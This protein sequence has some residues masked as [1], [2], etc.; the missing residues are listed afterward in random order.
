V[1][2]SQN[3]CQSRQIPHWWPGRSPCGWPSG[4][5]RGVISDVPAPCSSCWPRRGGTS[6]SAPAWPLVSVAAHRRSS[7]PLSPAVVSPARLDWYYGRLRRPPSRG[8]TS[9]GHRLWDAT[10]PTTRPPRCGLG[11]ATSSCLLEPQGHEDVRAVVQGRRGHGRCDPARRDAV[12]DVGGHPAGSPRPATP[13]PAP[14]W[15]P[16]RARPRRAFGAT[17]PAIGGPGA[18]L[19]IAATPD[20]LRGYARR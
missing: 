17:A 1:T 12:E 4:G 16:R 6:G 19:T 3:L 18:P 20:P 7:S 11:R 9:G 5:P 14:G 13:T 15:R 2:R 8:S 10:L